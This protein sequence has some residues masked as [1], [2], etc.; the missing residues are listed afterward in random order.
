LLA[1]ATQI[2][3][4][5]NVFLHRSEIRLSRGLHRIHA[6][7]QRIDRVAERANRPS[8]LDQISALNGVGRVRSGLIAGDILLQPIEIRLGGE[9]ARAAQ[10][11]NRHGK[12]GAFHNFH[13]AGAHPA[14]HEL[15]GH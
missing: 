10:K 5:L 6:S 1:L 12:R 7:A 2:L 11:R 14:T 8:N 15:S 13:R 9:E 3:E 4:L